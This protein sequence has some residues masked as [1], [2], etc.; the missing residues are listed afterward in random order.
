MN[1]SKQKKNGG[2][3]NLQIKFVT[4]AEEGISHSCCLHKHLI[5][6][7]LTNCDQLLHMNLF[8]LFVHHFIQHPAAVNVKKTFKCFLKW[9]LKKK[10]SC[11][12]WEGSKLDVLQVAWSLKR[13]REARK[14]K[15]WLHFTVLSVLIL[16]LLFHT[17]Q[18][19]RLNI[20]NIWCHANQQMY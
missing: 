20:T 6:T 7:E 9:I 17:W 10:L 4:H 8:A 14:D 16:H 3:L 13:G 2:I 11:S 15:V 12:F 1:L 18:Q 19:W 5:K